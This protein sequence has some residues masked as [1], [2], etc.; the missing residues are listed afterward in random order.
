[1][2]LWQRLLYHLGFRKD[3][4][5]RFFELDA[6]LHTSLSTLAKHEGRAEEEL[7]T[8]LLAAGMTHY[9]SQDRRQATALDRAGVARRC[10]RT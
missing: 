1:M 2:S 5:P 7:A 4:G 6:S 10:A 9:R 3:P 8:D